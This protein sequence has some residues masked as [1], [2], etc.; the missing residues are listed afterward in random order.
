MGVCR[1]PMLRA[2][3]RKQSFFISFMLGFK[4]KYCGQIKT[5]MTGKFSD[6]LFHFQ[7]GRYLEFYVAK[8]KA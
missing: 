6:T 5:D 1:K 4:L 7:A 3:D 2:P 8:M